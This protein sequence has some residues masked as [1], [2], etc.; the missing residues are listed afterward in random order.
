MGS[1]LKSREE[2]LVSLSI[3]NIAHYFFIFIFNFEIVEFE[4]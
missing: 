3:K 1:A 4:N 2:T